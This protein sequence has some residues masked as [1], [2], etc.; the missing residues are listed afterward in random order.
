M[1]SKYIVNPLFSDSDV[2]PLLT[3]VDISTLP[4]HINICL[5]SLFFLFSLTLLWSETLNNC[6]FNQAYIWYET[7]VMDYFQRIYQ[8]GGRAFWIH[9]TGP[10]GC[11]PVNF[12]YNHNPAPGYLDQHGCVKGQN[13]MAVEFNKQ[14]KD[15]VIKLRAELPEAAITYVDLYAAKYGLISNAKNEG[16]YYIVMLFTSLN[17]FHM[18]L[19]VYHYIL[20]SLQFMLL[21]RY[22]TFYYY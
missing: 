7:T 19:K 15:R 20:L 18:P 17:Q 8:Q 1:C 14:L 13:D 21:L 3:L 5:D 16:I 11:L 6:E 12:F 2:C 10:I 22:G 9:N 4:N